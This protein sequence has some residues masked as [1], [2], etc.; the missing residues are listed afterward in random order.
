MP[1]NYRLCYFYRPLPGLHSGL[2]EQG[3]SF[4]VTTIGCTIGAIGCFD[5]SFS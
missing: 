2:V 4:Q 3:Y 5:V 1:V